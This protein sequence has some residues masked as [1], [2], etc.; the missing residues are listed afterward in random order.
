MSELRPG[1]RAS[2]PDRARRAPPEPSILREALAGL[3]R[4]P[5]SLPS[6]LFYDDVGSRLFQWI[7]RIPDYYPTRVETEILERSG[8]RIAAQHAGRPVTLVDLGAGDG[9]KTQILVDHLRAVGARV[10]YAPVDV[11][12]AA[13]ELAAARMREAGPDVSVAPIHARYGPGVRR[14]ATLVPGAARLVLFLGSSIGN[15]ER[16]EALAFLRNVRTALAAGDRALVGFDLMKPRRILQR[17]YDDSQGVT[18]AFNL[19]LLARLNRE[20]GADFELSA[21]RHVA[22]FDPARPAMESWLESTRR[23]VVRFGGAA[24]GFSAGERIHTEIS[25]KYTLP[26]VSALARD[27]RFREE[28]HLVD[29][30]GWFVDA[31]WTVA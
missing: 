31:L 23:Q 18:R 29:A 27:A 14:A 25:C 2:P 20:C 4:R 1:T 8:A 5:R 12:P 9:H 3:G 17:A 13:L 6:H 26:R 28:D 19:N 16:P 22:T 30:R 21:W 10:T 24:F 15:L 7:T 11:S